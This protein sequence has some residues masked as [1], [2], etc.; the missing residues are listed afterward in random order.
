MYM[1]GRYS[2]S[3][4]VSCM[5]DAK[6]GKELWKFETGDQIVGGLTGRSLRKIPM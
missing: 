2:G 1:D 3:M 4:T 5:L 6:T